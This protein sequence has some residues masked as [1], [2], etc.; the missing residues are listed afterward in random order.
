VTTL[1]QGTAHTPDGV[2]AELLAVLLK[3]P[4][5]LAWER[6]WHE[7]GNEVHKLLYDELKAIRPQADIGRHVDHRQSSWDLFYRAGSR[8]QDMPD[9]ADFI[10]PILYHDILGPRLRK[11]YLEPLHQGILQE[12]SLKQSLEL[13]YALF[14]HASESQPSLAQL[15]DG[16]SPDYVF[17]E[18]K[19]AVEGAAGR[20]AV[21]SGIGL[22]IPKGS[23]WGT[24]TWQSD[25]DEVYRAVSKAFDAGAAGII[26][27]REYEEITVG[28]L[29][30]V[31]RAVRDRAATTPSDG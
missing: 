4:E 8:Y 20:A 29:R 28:S 16:L 23:G 10:K 6:M 17:N 2:M 9:H 27:S 25:P 12:L 13:F 3:Y 31:G 15:H 30:V 1:R 19:R 18:T 7:S 24:D 11:N 14:G 22:D 21:Y 5:L 26:A